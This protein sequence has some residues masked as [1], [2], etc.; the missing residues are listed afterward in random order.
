MVANIQ[1]CVAISVGDQ[2][3]L[4]RRDKPVAALPNTDEADLFLHPNS[5]G[6]GTP[7]PGIRLRLLG[8]PTMPT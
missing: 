2:S 6:R 4:G 1:T 7:T 8:L 3:L 5:V